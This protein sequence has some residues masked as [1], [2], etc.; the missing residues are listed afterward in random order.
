MMITT[1]EA[2]RRI[3]AHHLL[4]DYQARRVLA[5]GL[6]GPGLRTRG[7]VLYDEAAVEALIRRPRCD[8]TVLDR[9]RPFIARLG[10]RRAFDVAASWSE[11]VAQV[12]GG[13]YVPMLSDAYMRLFRPAGVDH[14]PFVAVIGG[15][16]VLGAEITG[17][18]FEDRP[19]ASN[20]ARPDRTFSLV[21]PGAWF[22][23]LRE[24]W[25]PIDNG[26]TWTLWGAPTATSDGL[27][28]LRSD[29]PL[30]AARKELR[31]LTRPAALR[32]AVT[33]GI[34]EVHGSAAPAAAPPPPS[35]TPEAS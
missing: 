24:T 8:E 9:W 27:D 3:T 15:W 33:Q 2:A 12:A 32:T 23:E 26:A 22:E 31:A 21:P 16:V 5:A 11:Q 25:L 34:C 20:R 17:S 1:R 7:A 29:Y 6:A 14:Q 28:S 18:A 35:A 13:W 4:S 10:R 19:A 30:Q